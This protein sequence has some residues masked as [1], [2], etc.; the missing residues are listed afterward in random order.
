MTVNTLKKMIKDGC[1]GE[2]LSIARRMV[3][4]TKEYTT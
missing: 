3:S 4:L 2:Y 1:L